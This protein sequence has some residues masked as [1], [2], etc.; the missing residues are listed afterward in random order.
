MPANVDGGLAAWEAT[1]VAGFGD[2]DLETKV[3]DGA[4]GTV[5]RAVH[6]ESGRR[7]AV[8]ELSPTLSGDPAFMAR[9][10]QLVADL[11]ALDEHENRVPV[12]ECLEENGRVWV[13]EPWV[14]GRRLD[15]MVATG[16]RGFTP[17]EAV[18]VVTGILAGLASAQGIV[19]GD[20]RPENIVVAADGTPLLT[21]FGIPVPAGEEDDTYRSA[22]AVRGDRLDARSDVYSAGAVLHQLL[23][24][25]PELAVG[26]AKPEPEPEPD[27]EPDVEVE[28]DVDV[29][30][31]T[32][33]APE[34]E[35]GA[36]PAAVPA[37]AVPAAP[38]PAAPAPK[39][40]QAG[41][42]LTR[43]VQRSLS[44]DPRKR[45]ARAD[46]FRTSL[47]R[48]AGECFDEGWHEKAV[49]GL[50]EIATT[51]PPAPRTEAARGE[52]EPTPLETRLSSRD[53]RPIPH[54]TVLGLALA[55]LL[56]LVVSTVTVDRRTGDALNRAAPPPT[57]EATPAEIAGSDIAG[58]WAVIIRVVE[59]SGIFDP[60]AGSAAV[61]AY[62]I[63]SDC[64]RTPCDYRL[65]VTGSPGEF[66]LP[67][68]GEDYALKEQGP[69]DCVDPA[70]GDI[71]VPGGGTATVD[72]SLRPTAARKDTAG[73]W[74]ATAFE[75]GVVTTFE[76]QN[77]DCGGG[78]GVQR[79][80]LTATRQ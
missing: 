38:A 53:R 32:D 10:R 1:N 79:T 37:A 80:A 34:P 29:E 26:E 30:P 69:N 17:E 61:K 31:D 50:A 76:S 20:V 11:V 25:T 75:G 4:R 8:K 36:E 16:N 3:G 27:A 45:P 22:E 62:V 44:E 46:T 65:T 78:S 60:S 67:R 6:V 49:S 19:H 43:L 74:V 66:A 77:A 57:P 56:L 28:P 73:G 39:L 5:W 40:S 59:T 58:T 71:R 13:V 52:L 41:K 21:D 72:V 68:V 51:P 42:K 64:S 2:Y 12:L 47:Q 24:G 23:G 9:Y 63:S 18:A 14:V 70:T 33:V 7:V 55:I 54:A 48:L 35:T 15:R